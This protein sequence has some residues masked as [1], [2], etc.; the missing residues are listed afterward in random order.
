MCVRLSRFACGSHKQFQALA[1]QARQSF[2]LSRTQMAHHDGREVT[3]TRDGDTFI[4]RGK[5]TG[6]SEENLIHQEAGHCASESG[7]VD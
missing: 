3:L 2:G 5:A 7:L 6:S 4:E 1:W